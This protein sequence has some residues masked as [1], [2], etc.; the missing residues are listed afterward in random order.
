MML[1]YTYCDVNISTIKNTNCIRYSLIIFLLYLVG[2][3]FILINS[4][5]EGRK[6]INQLENMA[7][8]INKSYSDHTKLNGSL[9]EV[10]FFISK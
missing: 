7:P 10:I 1:S 4:N 9:E 2:Y 6:F 5:I 3:L 8:V